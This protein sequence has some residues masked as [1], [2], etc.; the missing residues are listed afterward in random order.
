MKITL[1]PGV[2]HDGALLA[3]TAHLLLAGIKRERVIPK[4]QGT[5][6]ASHEVSHPEALRAEITASTPYARRLY[7][8]P[9]YNFRHGKNPNAKGAWFEDWEPGGKYEDRAAEIYAALHK[10]KYGG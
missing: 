2:L 7:M 1:A 4:D 10:E 5:L 8:H 6:E 3:E 9:E